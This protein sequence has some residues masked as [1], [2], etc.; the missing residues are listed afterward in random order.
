[1]PLRKAT[2]SVISP[3]ICTTDTAQTITGNKIFSNPIQG[4][5][6]GVLTGNVIGSASLNVLKTGDTMTGHLNVPAGAVGNETPRV[7]EVVSKTGDTMTGGLVVSTNT[8]TDALRVTQIGTGSALRVED[9]ANPDATPFIITS[10]GS[11]GIGTSSPTQKLDVSGSVNVS[12]SLTANTVQATAGGGFGGTAFLSQSGIIVTPNSLANIVVFNGAITDKN[13]TAITQDPSIGTIF[14]LT[15]SSHGLQDYDFITFSGQTAN[16]V[17]FNGT[18]PIRLDSVDPVNKFWIQVATLPTGVL[19]Q[20]M[21]GRIVRE[22]GRGYGDYVSSI[23]KNSLGDFTINFATTMA[24]NN[25]LVFGS[26]SNPSATNVSYTTAV[27]GVVVPW[28]FDTTSLRVATV[29]TSTGAASD[30]SRISVGIVP[31]S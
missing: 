6:D 12:S 25:Y 29:L 28:F 2:Q 21:T 31:N 20:T 24:D 4:N 30:Y 9:S 1:M 26:A 18:F 15:C 17:I 10:S 14:Y 27:R 16:N 11:V 8:S 19:T 3:N 5:V 13:I 23:T 22:Y 7:S